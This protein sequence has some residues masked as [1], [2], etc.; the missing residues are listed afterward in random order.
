MPEDNE[1]I[2]VLV[3]FVPA[4]LAIVAAFVLSVEVIFMRKSGRESSDGGQKE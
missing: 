2:H 1:M 4:S 3:Y